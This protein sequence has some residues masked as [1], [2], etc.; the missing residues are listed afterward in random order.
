MGYRKIVDYLNENGYR[1]R[2]GKVFAVSTIQR[3][4]SNSIYIGLKRYK[5]AVG[6]MQPFNERL[7]IISDELFSQAEQIRN[8][9]ISNIKEQ[10]KSDIQRTDIYT[11]A[12][13]TKRFHPGIYQIH[14]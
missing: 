6:G 11:L 8:K 10:D 14:Q 2:D 13:R 5:N 3:I 9:R 1:N 4:L 7:R 12:E